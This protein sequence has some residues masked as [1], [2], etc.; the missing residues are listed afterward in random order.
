M[1][2]LGMTELEQKQAA[3]DAKK[4]VQKNVQ[5][6]VVTEIDIPFMSL[7]GFMIKVAIAAVPAGIIVSILW[8]MVASFVVGL[9]R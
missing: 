5:H 1:N 6:V 4:N 3:W 8:T 2:E 7:V 9:T